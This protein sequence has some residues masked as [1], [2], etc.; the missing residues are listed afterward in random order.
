[1]ASVYKIDTVSG[2]SRIEF[3]SFCRDS[4]FQGVSFVEIEASEDIKGKYMKVRP[5][6]GVSP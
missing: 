5:F 3:P 1:M 2:H 4:I 6:K